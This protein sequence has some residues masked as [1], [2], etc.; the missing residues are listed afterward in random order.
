MIRQLLKLPLKIDN[1]TVDNCAKELHFKKVLGIRDSFITS[2][3]VEGL[4]MT[5]NALVSENSFNIRLPCKFFCIGDS[6]FKATFAE[7]FNLYHCFFTEHRL[8]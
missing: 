7:L 3:I 8:L 2:F 1:G 4:T 5:S 6:T